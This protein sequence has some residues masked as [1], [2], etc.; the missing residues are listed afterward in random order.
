MRF[1]Y[2]TIFILSLFIP[3]IFSQGVLPDYPERS[4]GSLNDSLQQ[5]GAFELP[6]EATEGSVV[7]SEYIVGP[8]D[9]LLVSVN[10][11]EEVNLTLMIDQEGN[12]FVPKV[13][14]INLNRLN[15]KTAKEKIKSEILKYYKNVDVVISLVDFRKIKVSL[16]GDVKQTAVFTLSSNSRLFDLIQKS[17]GFTGTSDFRN[18]KII[19][20][21]GD[22]S[23]YDFLSFLRLG[24]KRENPYLHEGDIVIVYK[25]DKIVY[26]DGQVLYPGTY[27]Y[28]KNETI[29][30][31]IKLAGGFT[32]KARKDSVEIMSFDKNGKNLLSSYYNYSDLIKDKIIA[33]PQD[34]IAIRVIPE[35]YINRYVKV[36]GY[37]QY[38]GYYKVIK[39][40][41]TLLDVINQAGGFTP[42]ASL[43][44]AT[45]TRHVGTTRI[46]PEFERLKTMERKDMTDEEYEYLKAK[47]RQRVGDVVVDFVKLFIDHDLAENVVLRAQDVITVPKERNYIIM[48]GQLVNPGNIIYQ[49]GLTVDDYIRLAGGYSWRAMTGDVRVVRA[50][51]GEWVDADDVDSLKPGDTI[52]VPEKPEGPTF[53]EVF[54]TTLSILGQVGA[55]VAATAAIIIAARK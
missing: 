53:W 55:I 51:T 25:V 10:G 4:F 19:S 42:E 30:N 37:V 22:T 12:L 49:P 32:L 21:E 17:M 43:S 33:Q 38:P 35:Y 29:A 31:L 40:H 39:N 46:D 5:L 44:D 52:W 11:I 48:L 28:V 8:G 18:I 3:S 2:L 36:D 41:T 23:C 47:S 6:V 27:E 15:L 14:I 9:K 20:R 34:R 45:L 50:K 16:L 54:T 24:D 1:T 13:G 26:V 7:D